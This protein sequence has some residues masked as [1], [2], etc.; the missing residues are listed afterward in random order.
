MENANSTFPQG[1]NYK[2]QYWPPDMGK[3]IHVCA[4]SPTRKGH[5]SEPLDKE[6]KTSPFLLNHKEIGTNY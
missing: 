3:K 5:P 6:I 2:G 4:G 1:P